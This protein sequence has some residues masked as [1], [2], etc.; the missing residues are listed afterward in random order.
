MINTAKISNFFQSVSA[1][2]NFFR[3]I[4]YLNRTT[5]AEAEGDFNLKVQIT[6]IRAQVMKRAGRFSVNI[7]LI[8]QTTW[9][10]ILAVLNLQ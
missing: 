1:N 10:K 7:R 9:N 6:R 5:F 8:L 3:L 2:G 4:F